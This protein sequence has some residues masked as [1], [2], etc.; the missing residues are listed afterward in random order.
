MRKEDH[1]E[2]G[3]AA[4]RGSRRLQTRSTVELKTLRVIVLAILLPLIRAADLPAQTNDKQFDRISIEQGLSQTTVY[5]ILQDTKGFMWFGTRDGLNKHNGYDFTVYEQEHFKAFREEDP[6]PERV[7]NQILVGV[8]TRNYESSL[9]KPA[10]KLKSR[11][12]SKSAAS[13]HLVSQTTKKLEQ[14]L[15]RRLEEY[16][17]AALMM[18]GLEVAGQTVVVTLG[19]TIDGTKVPLGIWLGSTENSQV[20]HRDVAGPSR[21]RIADR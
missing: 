5:C 13:R 7:L 19:I 2:N 20:L 14:Y 17:L 16:E 6:L 18:D 12:T 11:G 8:S 21:A 1:S 10:A 9:D 4:C 3:R 15:S